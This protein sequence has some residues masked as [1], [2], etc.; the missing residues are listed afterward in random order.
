MGVPE[1]LLHIP[2]RQDKRERSDTRGSGGT[3]RST[4][5]SGSLV[6]QNGEYRHELVPMDPGL[7]RV[8]CLE[9]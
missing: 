6:Y 8:P 1:G 2:G 9:P 3:G 4:N 5:T 7:T